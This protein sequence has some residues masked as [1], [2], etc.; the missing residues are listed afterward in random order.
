MGNYLTASAYASVSSRDHFV[1]IWTNQSPAEVLRLSP[2][3][4]V[5]LTHVNLCDQKMSMRPDLTTGVRS[6]FDDPFPSISMANSDSCADPQNKTG[7]P[8]HFYRR[9]MQVPAQS[10]EWDV[11]RPPKNMT[12][13]IL[14][15][16][17]WLQIYLW[18]VEW[19]SFSR[20]VKVSVLYYFF[21]M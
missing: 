3:V 16:S 18:F 4:N 14:H 12:C 13:V 9:L 5:K 17:G 19:T 10:A 11:N 7:H 1:I 15:H 21:F 8:V 6:T 2:Y 20:R